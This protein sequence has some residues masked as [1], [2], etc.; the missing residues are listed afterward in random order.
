MNNTSNKSG[1]DFSSDIKFIE[2][3]IG[4]N[5]TDTTNSFNN[6]SNIII[7]STDDYQRVLDYNNKLE[8]NKNKN[9]LWAEKTD[10]EQRTT[11]YRINNYATYVD[12]V[13][14]SNPLIYPT[15]YDEH[16]DYL[17]KK[18]INP[19]NTQVVKTKNYINIDSANRNVNTFLNIDKYI[20]LQNYSLE[21]TNQS[22]Y[23]KIYLDNADTY[24]KQNDY[25]I[26]RGFK[27]YDIYYEK[28][29]FFFTNDSPAVVI[30]LKPNF[31]EA[32]SY[33]DIFIRIGGVL[34]ENGSTFWKN[35]P[36]SLINDLHKVYITNSNGDYRLGFDLP[37][38][39]YSSNNVDK[40]L[41]SNC[42]IE[43]YCLG[44]YPINLINSNTPLLPNSL[45]NYLIVSEITQNYIKLILSNVLSLNKNIML[46]GIWDGNVFRTGTNIQIGKIDSFIQGYPNPN[47]FVIN[48]DK[49]Y[50][51]VCSIKMVSSEIFNFQ[52]NIT[53]IDQDIGPTIGDSNLK[54]IKNQNNKFY[55][56]N[57]L[58]EGIYS[59][60]LIPG[61]YSY[62]QLKT[63]IE[64]KVSQVKRNTIG[65]NIY[66]YE[67]NS[68]DVEFDTWNNISNFKL[69]N[70]YILPN[71]LES[72]SA[73][74]SQNE[75]NGFIIKI[76]HPQHNLK[77]GDRIF[78]SGSI[79]Y[80][81]ID[82]SYI[83][84]SY[85]HII[86]N[87]I[88][89]NLYEITI[90]DINEIINV[91]DT[92][93]GYEI[94]IKTYACF[95]LFFNFNDTFGALMG[96]IFV[97]LPQSITAYSSSE[98]EYIINNIQPYYYDMRK[99]LIV[100]NNV[101]PYDLTINFSK[102]PYAYILLL[103]EDLNNN[104]NPNGPSYFYKILLN[105]QSNTYL[106]NTF[107]QSPIYFN[108]P[109]KSLNNFKFTFILP[110][111]GLVNFGSQNVSFTLEI[112]TLDNLPENTNLTTYMSRI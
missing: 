96:F 101:S 3:H 27:N 106:Y 11:V 2:K 75:H 110:N 61:Y 25:I 19:I 105:G 63:T 28:L 12:D 64:N 36:L 103:A 21:F 39:F 92:K 17:H 26:L 102:Q 45:N 7:N 109:I 79:D 5:Q 16:F 13:N 48:L 95:R 49:S 15:E 50:N 29:N 23:F 14:V 87:V 68:I 73:I 104:Y 44:N 37:I 99:V 40:T 43:F 112:T 47:N 38:N 89:N 8:R 46:D 69:Y 30:D 52:K 76:N 65:N 71:C 84:S 31:G 9:D 58:D 83:N 74:N 67:Y 97:G 80:Y 55:W 88:N 93:G 10:N 82:K 35:I 53:A 54:Y 98:Y 57:I 41:I 66:L 32:I 72:I 18:N 107:V 94:K 91:G 56:Q 86:T 34:L 108:P 77:K 22:N 51:N 85:G 4:G 33:Y 59:I 100:N 42:V 24:F 62:E 20:N 6:Q 81:T 60:E 78:I 70:I 90:S 1:M 111:G